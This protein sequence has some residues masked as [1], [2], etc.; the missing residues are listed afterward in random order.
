MKIKIREYRKTD[1]NNVKNII[2]ECLIEIF[3]KPHPEDKW[4]NFNEYKRNGGKFYLAEENK[5]IIGSI[6]I[7]NKGNYGILKRMY[8]KKEYRGK[9]I[10]QELLRKIIA[11]ARKKKYKKIELTTHP[12][13][14]RAKLFYLKNDF[15]IIEILPNYI[16]FSRELKNGNHKH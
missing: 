7:I 3:G 12:K 4:E 16:K 15:N 6:A 8:I 5:I 9:G 14:K 11:F 2:N 1:E 10:S 13:M